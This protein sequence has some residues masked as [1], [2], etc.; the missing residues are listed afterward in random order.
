MTNHR[1]L[2]IAGEDVPATG[3]RTVDDVN[4][5]T[6]E[7]FA[8][9]AAATPED[10]TKAVDAADAAFPGWAA[11][12]PFARRKILLDA[13][14]LLD[15]RKE[16]AVELMAGEVGGTTR[17][18]A[19]NVFLAANILREAAA[20]VTAP[21]GEVLAAQ[22]EGALGL[23][24]REPLGVVAAFAPWNAPLILGTRAFAAPI[25]AGNTVV[26][27]PSEE[28]P[29]ASGLFLADVLRE[30]GLPAGVLNVVTNDPQDAAAVAESLIADPRVRVVNFTGSTE[31]GRIIGTHAARHLKPAVLE[32][33]GKNAII[34]LDDADLDH[35]VD[36][37][38]FGVFMNSG[39]ICMSGD[40]VL[41]HEKVADEFTARFV[42]K[43]AA[44]P[45]GDPT[46][47]DT[48][49]GPL[50]STRSAERVAALVRDA[51]A[52]GATVLTGGDG[53]DGAL[54]PATVLSGITP[55]MDLHYGEAFGPVCVL[56]TFSSD[57]E[58]VA[59]AN[60]TDHGLTCGILT[61]NGT[62]GLTLARRIRTGIVHV[63]DQSV[64]DEPQAPFGGVKS[65]GYGRFG[66]RWGVEA[67]TT[68]R[69]IT[70]ATAHAH[71]PF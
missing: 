6:G 11:L 42:A 65:S 60:D 7:V 24:V 57:D 35:A 29:L 48:V 69:W 58:A 25:A 34:V 20:S 43:V 59:R 2:L 13:A 33:G 26:L 1:N 9:V 12:S 22:E 10:V 21:R 63:N 14:D 40:R 52:K 32:L 55:D 68:T 51:R 53:P 19:F 5:F 16:Q 47:P 17:W 8:T 18:A 31:V 39:Q 15:A 56:E 28:A 49:I 66:G 44:L 3:G 38:A 23:A 64:G 54:H 70:L 41:V 62:R 61:E 71:Y 45:H 67:F 4:P 46:D 37:A 27:K 30:A 36:A 50:V